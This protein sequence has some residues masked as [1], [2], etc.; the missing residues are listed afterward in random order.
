VKDESQKKLGIQRS[1]GAVDDGSKFVGKNVEDPIVIDWL[2][3][4]LFIKFKICVFRYKT[5]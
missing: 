1:N 5:Y 2:I 3:I 4:Y